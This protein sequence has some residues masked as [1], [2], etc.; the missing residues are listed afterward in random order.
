MES[1]VHSSLTT[2][3]HRWPIN[4]R[5]R[6]DLRFKVSSELKSEDMIPIC[7]KLDSTP[8]KTIDND[9]VA[10][11]AWFYTEGCIVND[12][13]TIGI[14]QSNEVNPDYCK[15][16]EGSL[17]RTFGEDSPNM[18]R[19]DDE[20]LWRIHTSKDNKKSYYVNYN[21]AKDFTKYCDGKIPTLDFIY[22]LTREQ[23]QLFI[24]ISI[25]A[26]GHVTKKGQTTFVQKNK[27]MV[28]RFQLACILAGY[29]TTIRY[30]N[31]DNCYVVTVLHRTYIQPFAISKEN[32][33]KNINIIDYDGPVYCLTTKNSTWL[34]RREFSVYFTGNCVPLGIPHSEFLAW[35]EDDQDKAIAWNTAKAQVCDLCGSREAEWI[36]PETKRILDNPPLVPNT[37]KCYG[38]AEIDVYRKATFQDEPVPEGVRIVLFP[39]EM[40]DERGN[41]KH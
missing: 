38:C 4:N 11:V 18:W 39:S 35:S 1:A 13:G 15:M 9:I 12:I 22:S 14:Y 24:D 30:R 23:L 5:W 36:D 33:S 3:D 20:K 26:D 29:G 25:M 19:A 16:I 37:I 28:E 27:T 21:A 41:H 34:A 32:F 6:K 2:M 10:L 8:E 7:A 31:L 17:Y 40:I